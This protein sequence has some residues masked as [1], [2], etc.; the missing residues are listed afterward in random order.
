MAAQTNHSADGFEHPPAATAPKI[1]LYTNHNC[2]YAHRAHIALEE[3]QLPFEEVIIDLSTPRPQWYLDIN[4]RG[5]VPT[6]KYSVP[7]ILDEEIITESAIVA[8]F[9]AD[10]RPSHLLPA[11]LESPFAPL[12]RARVAFFTD[13]WNSKIASAMFPILLAKSDEEVQTKTEALYAAMEKEIEPLLSNAGPFFDGAQQMT[14]AEVIVAP[15]LVRLWTL[16]GDGEL[17]PKSFRERVE[18]LPNFNKWATAVAGQRSVLSV[19]DAEASVKATK[20]RMAKVKAG[21]K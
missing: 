16:S 13:T 5:L 11:S 18:R 12:K 4:P 21:G 6:I 14:F 7:G 19:F 2:P 8:Q 10:S 1:T 20:E 9:L 15:T 17:I 3:L